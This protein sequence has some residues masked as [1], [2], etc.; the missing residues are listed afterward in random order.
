MRTGR[1]LLALLVL[2]G[3]SST[4]V[5]KQAATR[6]T[7]PSLTAAQRCAAAA[8]LTRGLVFPGWH[9]GAVQFLTGTSGVGITAERLPCFRPIRGGAEVGSE[10]QSVRLAVTSDGGRSWRT[11]GATLPVGSVRHGVVA[12]HIA[13]L[14]RA[15][16]WAVVGRGRLVATHDGGSDWQVQTVP[17]PVLTTTIDNGFVWAVSCPHA[18]AQTSPLACRP[19]LWRSRPPNGAWTQVALPRARTQ[20]PFTVHFAIA[21]DEVMLAL[22]EASAR[23]SGELLSSQD[24]GQHWTKRRAPTWDHSRC[25]NGAELAAQAPHTFWLLCLGGA[26]AGSSTKGLLRSTDAGGTWTTVSAVTSLTRPPRA[27]AIPLAEPSAL[28]AGSQTRLWLSLTNGL[29]ESNDGGRRWMGVPRAFDPGGW[30]TVIDVFDADHAWALA[31]GAGLWRTT[32]GLHWR[33]I[34]PLNTE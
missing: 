14:S 28:A 24:G 27:G 5:T 8:R 15:D 23:P 12:E 33:A 6:A 2:A 7:R 9:M 3:C 1:L 31:S 4:V 11:T 16:V 25:D 17:H 34:G 29:A 13:A 22:T 30:S 20:D 21:S 10:S 26:A 32:D 19:E 18:A